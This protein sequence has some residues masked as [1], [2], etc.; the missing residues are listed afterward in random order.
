MDKKKRFEVYEKRYFHELDT[1]ERVESR[2]KTPLTMFA[3]V[4]GIIA[5]L[6]NKVIEAVD[7]HQDFGFWLFYSGSIVMFV[8]SVYFFIRSIYGYHYSLLPTPEVMENYYRNIEDEYA[9]TNLGSAKAWAQE[10][11]ED[12]LYNSYVQY[13][14]QNTKNNDA[15]SLNLIRCIGSIIFSFAC[16]VVSFVPI[17]YDVIMSRFFQ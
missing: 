12:Y 5:F 8:L 13:T 14:T 10:A 1:R 16:I 6:S 2:L 3:I 4:F 17:Y 7:T 11:F 15:K 9:K